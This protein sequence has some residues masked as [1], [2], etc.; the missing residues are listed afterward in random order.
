MSIIYLR[1]LRLDYSKKPLFILLCPKKAA[2]I[3]LPE[4]FHCPGCEEE[5]FGDQRI[6]GFHQS[7]VPF[8]LV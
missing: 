6:A 8:C 2:L 4:K 3:N 7:P 1:K 5:S